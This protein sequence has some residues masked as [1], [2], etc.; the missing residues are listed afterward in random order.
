ESERLHRLID[1]I[2]DF[3]RLGEGKRPFVLAEG[4]VT[5]CVQEAIVL[6][7]HSAEVRGFELYLDLPA[8]GALPPVDLDRDAIVRCVLNLLSNAVKYSGDSKYVRVSCRR[9]GDLIAAAVEDRG[10]GIEEEDLDRIFE[11]FYRVGDHLTR[12]VSGAGLGLALVDEVIRSHGGQIRVESTKGKGSTFTILLPIVPDYR[13]VAWPP[14]GSD[15]Q[16]TP[17]ADKPGGGSG[18]VPAQESEPRA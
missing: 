18:E 13:N 8:L 3:A 1:D 11:R 14:A 7:R 16:A 15:V 5:E 17:P 6:F 9:E 2:L 4:D 12:E 10:I